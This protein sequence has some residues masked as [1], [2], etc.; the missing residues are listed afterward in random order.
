MR[1]VPLANIAIVLPSDS[2]VAILN[3]RETIVSM[4]APKVV[5][6]C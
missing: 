3:Y 2:I 1:L 4:V 5:L 6:K